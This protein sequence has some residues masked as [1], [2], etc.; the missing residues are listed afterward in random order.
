VTGADVGIGQGI[1]L[2]VA[3][4]GATVAVHHPP[5]GPGAAE[6]VGL[7]AQAGYPA[8]PVEGDLADRAACHAVVDQ[9]AERLGGLDALVNNAG[10]TRTSPVVD[11][12]AEFFTGLLA[13]NFG[14]QFFCA[15]RAV[16]HFPAGGGG[17]IVNVSSVHASRGFP[18]YTVY[19]A[20][21]GAVEAW[22]RTL[23]MELA[24]SIRVNAVAPGLVETPRVMQSIPDYS[25]ERVGARN[26]MGRPGFP[27]DVADVVIFL[28]SDLSR[29][30]TGQVLHVD[31]GSTAR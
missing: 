23:A 10:V 6:T 19:A 13:L 29:Y 11:I 31:G 22:T 20:A 21:K 7:L 18:T 16:T 8:V 30:V 27:A 17:S 24:P 26:P 25:R 4:A 9:A 5:A 15:Q 28:L 1:A 2:A 3:A 12:D 14:G